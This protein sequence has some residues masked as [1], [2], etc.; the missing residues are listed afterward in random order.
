M[1]PQ[2]EPEVIANIQQVIETGKPLLDQELTVSKLTMLGMK[3]QHLL[4]SYY[5]VRSADGVALGVGAVMVDITR[6][7]QAQEALRESKQRYRVTLA[8]IGDAVIATDRQGQVTFINRIAE[9]LT[10]W[11]QPEVLGKPLEDVFKIVNEQSRATVENPGSKSYA[12][13][14]SSGWRTTLS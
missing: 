5:R 8:S 11:Q 14:E 12:K 6:I 10:G 3:R 2:I 1:Q 7:K 9:D 13:G 4:T